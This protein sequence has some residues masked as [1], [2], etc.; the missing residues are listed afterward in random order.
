M[1]TK[2]NEIYLIDILNMKTKRKFKFINVEN[3]IK[4]LYKKEKDIY[5]NYG[6]YLYT[7]KYNK[8]NLEILTII[9]KSQF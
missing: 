6:N 9:R 1:I 3:E 4:S 7:I 2:K 8:Y 5:L